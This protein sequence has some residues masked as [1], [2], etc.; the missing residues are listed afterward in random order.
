MNKRVLVFGKFDI[1][2]PGHKHIL[3]LAKKL[4]K[5]IVVLESDQ[6]IKA[7][8][9]RAPYYNQ[10]ARKNKLEALGFKVFIRTTDHDALYLINHLQP[11][12]LCLGEDQKLLQ[13]IFSDFPNVNLEIIKFVKKN[14]YKSSRMQSILEDREAGLYLIDKP[15]G[16]NSF[17]AVA[18]VRKVLNMRRV[19]FSGTLDPLASGLL[20]VATGRA[21]RLLDWF[22]DLPKHYEAKIVFGKQSASYDLETPVLENKLAQA[23]TKK[24]LEKTLTS[25]VGKQSQTVPIYSAKKVQGE[26]LYLLAR[27]GQNIQAPRQ[28]IEIYKLKINKFDYPYLNLSATVSSGTYIRSLAH[29]LGKTMKTGAVLADLK[30]TAIGDFKLKKSLALNELTRASLV[31]HKIAVETIIESLS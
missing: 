6:A 17:R 28:E 27:A 7:F 21:T 11:D 4:G 25:F 12:I 5:V 8:R 23:F 16:V 15:K 22:H 18:V 10:E 26:K 13:K 20:I 24:Q 31:K 14:L 2:H 1:F 19:G 3:T 9:H 30:R 29:D